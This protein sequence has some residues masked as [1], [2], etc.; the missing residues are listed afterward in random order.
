[1]LS[2]L[3]KGCAQQRWEGYPDLTELCCS[4]I[5]FLHF[6]VFVICVIDSLP[7]FLAKSDEY[8]YKLADNLL[9]A[10]TNGEHS[11]S[12]KEMDPV[13]KYS[14]TTKPNQL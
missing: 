1:M 13:S 12:L 9:D 8:V 11:K 2:V 3:E 6:F 14:V 10:L 7:E 4:T 5:K